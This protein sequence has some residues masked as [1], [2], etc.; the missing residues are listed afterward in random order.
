MISSARARTAPIAVLLF[1]AGTAD[2]QVE[3]TGLFGWTA[4]LVEQRLIYRPRLEPAGRRRN[5]SKW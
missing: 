4:P 3:V 1:A 2:A 5:R